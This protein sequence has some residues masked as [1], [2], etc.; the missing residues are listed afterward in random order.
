MAVCRQ[1]IK[2]AAL[3]ERNR[4]GGDMKQLLFGMMIL[5]MTVSCGYVADNG[6]EFSKPK[7][8]S[9]ASK[10]VMVGFATILE[11]VFRPNCFG[12]HSSSREAGGIQL[13]TYASTFANRIAIRSAIESGRMPLGRN[14]SA[15]SK[16]QLFDWIDAGAPESEVVATPEGAL[17]Q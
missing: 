1:S 13:E 5:A 14:M 8:T 17:V 7:G 6:R 9:D 3:S 2:S 11:T 12:C 15:E 4:K 16:K 10:V